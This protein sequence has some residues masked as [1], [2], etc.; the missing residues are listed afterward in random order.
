MRALLLLF[1]LLV[2]A[3]GLLACDNKP[4]GPAPSRFDG[5]KRAPATAAATTFCEKQ[6]P[7]AEGAH[8]FTEP[9]EKAIPGAPVVPASTV[10]GWK[11][12]NLWATWCH[13][14]IEEIPL[15]GR[16]QASLEK[17][18]VPLDL[19]MWSV[20]EDEAALTGWL[21]KTPMPGRVKW[22]RSAEDLGPTLESLGADKASAIP[23]H[24]LVD[25]AG[26]LRC[27]RVGS[28]HDEDYGAIKSI[29]TGA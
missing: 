16:W 6:W 12:V 26:M 13:P 29:L 8:K 5:V 27:L 28:V 4:A 15:L 19:E 1:V 7:A 20:D 17:D 25:P 10:K 18:G 21:Q 3:L 14:C 2:L 24:A 9:P 22:L 11:W 23:V